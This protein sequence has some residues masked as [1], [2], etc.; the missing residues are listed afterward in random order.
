MT[1]VM[2]EKA[3]EDLETRHVIEK[4]KKNAV[5]EQGQ[6]LG[7]D[8]EIVGIDVV[9]P[10]QD[11]VPEIETATDINDDTVLVQ[12]I[13]IEGEDP[14]PDREIEKTEKDREVVIEI[15]TAIVIEIEIVDQVVNDLKKIIIRQKKLQLLSRRQKASILMLEM[16]Q[17]LQKF[18][19]DLTIR[20]IM[21]H[22]IF[23]T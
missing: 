1:S 12:G 21:H 17:A 7:T 20:K 10:D 23:T 19:L 4:E 5:A 11:R 13:E 16:E 15:V 14:E 8:P 6:D 22:K 3:V 9:D 18:P 2:W